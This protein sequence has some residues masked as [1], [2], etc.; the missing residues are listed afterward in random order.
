[1]SFTAKLINS[2]IYPTSD[3]LMIYAI[4]KQDNNYIKVSYKST[5]EELA[6][7][8][9]HQGQIKVFSSEEP[10]KSEYKGSFVPMYRA[11]ALKPIIKED[12]QS[13]F[14]LADMDSSID[15]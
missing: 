13:N 5:A 12:T 10:T 6:S 2:F 8:F 7:I 11:T 1:M 15:I 9:G 4:F 3:K 14:K